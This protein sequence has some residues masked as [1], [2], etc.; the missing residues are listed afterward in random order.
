MTALI[1]FAGAGIGGVARYAL[2]GWIQA[3]AG[4]PFPWGTLAINVSGSFV[5]A[6]AYAALESS[7]A[8]PEWRIFVGIGLCGGYTTFSTFSYEAVRLMQDGDWGRVGGYVLASVGLS[9]A[10]ALLGFRVAAALIGR[11]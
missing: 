6:L 2:G 9:L 4:T 8:A 11:S 3:L 10:A 5:L 7:A 1:V